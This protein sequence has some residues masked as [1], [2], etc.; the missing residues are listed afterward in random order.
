MAGDPLHIA[1]AGQEI[2]TYEEDQI[3]LL[4]ASGQLLPSDFFWRPGMVDW[5]P[6]SEL[7]VKQNI[8][9]FPRPVVKD[10]N[11]LD[12][13]LSRQHRT[14]GLAMLWDL[15]A[16]SPTECR[17]SPVDILEIEKKTGFDVQS[18]CKDDLKD[19]YRGAVRAY[20]VDRFL[21]PQENVNL[22]NLAITFGFD[23]QTVHA[24]NKEGFT[25]YF[26]NSLR[27][28][29]LR[30]VP[31]A[32]KAKQVKLL[33]QDVPL[34]PEDTV[35]I[36]RDVLGDYFMNLVE[37]SV[38]RVDKD[39]LISPEQVCTIYD[40][41][42]SFDTSPDFYGTDFA[43]R[44]SRAQI[45]WSYYREPLPERPCGLELGSEPCY[46]S[47]QV[48]LVENKRVVT[49]RTYSGFSAS[50]RSFFGVRY[51]TG[52]YDIERITE[53]QMT[54]IDVGEVVFTD[55]RVIFSG[56][57]KNFNIRYTKIIE[58]NEWNNA[59]QISRDSGGDV[60][61]TF[62]GEVHVANLILRRLVQEAKQAK[63]R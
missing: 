24:L 50:T 2:G 26:Q 19:W 41:L 28:I 49:H 61:F 63:S 60:Y 20:L 59:V 32:E 52:S 18:R 58:V 8:L 48:N 40:L 13:M 56:A 42:R 31:P 62:Q 46:W 16:T 38:Q 55:T 51:R 7:G 1:R 36:R 45:A 3:R 12:T 9:P 23:E 27:A 10:P 53:D 34:S 29:L 17:V 25:D 5:K 47:K 54:K 11:L 35:D 43:N 21:S 6:L 30:D 57:Y 37:K 39:E 14:E 22:H 15:L 4:L 44:L 33:S